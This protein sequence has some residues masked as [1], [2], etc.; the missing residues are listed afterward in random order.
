M[1]ILKSKFLCTTFSFG[2]KTK[3]HICILFN[4]ICIHVQKYAANTPKTPSTEDSSK[5]DDNSV[6]N[7]PDQTDIQTPKLFTQAPPARK[8]SSAT[9]IPVPKVRFLDDK[10]KTD[11]DIYNQ[12]FKLVPLFAESH[13]KPRPASRARLDESTPKMKK[14]HFVRVRTSKPVHNINQAKSLPTT[15]VTFTAN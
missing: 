13:L 5:A 7:M 15:F 3:M 10:Q 6:F 14:D 11:G 9:G 8:L 4:T 2:T 1:L 12:E